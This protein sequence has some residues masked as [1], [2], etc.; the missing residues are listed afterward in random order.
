[1]DCITADCQACYRSTMISGLCSHNFMLA[2]LF[3]LILET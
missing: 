1:M 3:F 2:V